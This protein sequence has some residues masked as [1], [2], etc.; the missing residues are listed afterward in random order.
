MV[1]G[2]HTSHLTTT[3][4]PSRPVTIKLSAFR[5]DGT[6]RGTTDTTKPGNRELHF[7]RGLF[8]Y[9]RETKEFYEIIIILMITLGGVGELKQHCPT[10]EMDWWRLFYI[11]LFYC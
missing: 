9:S 1:E 10:N 2:T 5:L 7:L 8:D 3:W 4:G 11:E 6:G